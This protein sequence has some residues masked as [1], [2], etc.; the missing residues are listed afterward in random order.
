MQVRGSRWARSDLTFGPVGRVVATV[1]VLIPVWWLLVWAGP[2]GFGCLVIYGFF[3]VPWALRDIWR[4]VRRRATEAEE[5]QARL[6]RELARDRAAAAAVPDDGI[7][8]RPA[9]PRW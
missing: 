8:D 7:T 6:E 3:L 2:F 4:P 5:L 9:P 1:G